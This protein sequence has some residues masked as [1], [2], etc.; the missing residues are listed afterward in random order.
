MSTPIPS[1]HPHPQPY[2]TGVYGDQPM[3]APEPKN[4]FAITALV[5]GLVGIVFALVP[6]TGFIAVILG[7]IGLV[8]GLVNIGRI[9]RGRSTAKTMTWFG[10]II[11]TLALAGGIWGMVVVFNAVDDLDNDLHCID[12]AKTAKQVNAC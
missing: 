4:G 9:R 12:Q 8:F 3:P 6:L 5:V 10:S 1:P 7:L 11:S 2:P